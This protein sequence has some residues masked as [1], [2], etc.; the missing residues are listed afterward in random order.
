MLV[1][2]GLLVTEVLVGIGERILM[3]ASSCRGNLGNS[4]L[5]VVAIGVVIFTVT[6]A[7]TFWQRFLG[8][9][10]QRHGERTFQGLRATNPAVAPKVN[11][12]ATKF[13]AG[14]RLTESMWNHP[15]LTALVAGAFAAVLFGAVIVVGTFTQPS[16]CG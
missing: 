12:R 2:G 1:L 3:P 5:I 6:A 10:I 8:R 14:T 13:F 15:W 9:R 4:A 16:T 11:A 7:G